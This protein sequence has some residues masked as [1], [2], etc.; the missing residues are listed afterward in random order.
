MCDQSGGMC[1]PEQEVIRQFLKD[2]DI[3]MG[4]HD[5]HELCNDVSRYRLEIQGKLNTMS[6][7]FDEAKRQHQELLDLEQGHTQRYMQDLAR[8]RREISALTSF[9]ATSSAAAL[10]KIWL[11]K[12]VDCRPESQEIMSALKVTEIA[13]AT[14]PE[15]AAQA[16]HKLEESCEKYEGWMT[17]IAKGSR[18]Y[19]QFHVQE[20]DR[21]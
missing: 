8:A 10:K 1:W 12:Q 15:E 7:E 2:A 13:F 4:Q 18:M 17:C 16:V 5:I 21:A 19:P 6:Q 3:T 14:T 11:I 20:V 9:A